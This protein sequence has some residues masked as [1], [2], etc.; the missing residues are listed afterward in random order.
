MT[1]V[2]DQ[3]AGLAEYGDPAAA[4]SLAETL[5]NETAADTQAKLASALYTLGKRDPEA[6]SVFL[7]AHAHTLPRSTIAAAGKALPEAG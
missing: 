1:N 5:V 4:M 6:L 2:L 7:A 3:L